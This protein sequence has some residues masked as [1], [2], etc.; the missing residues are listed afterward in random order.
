MRKGGFEPPPPCEDQALNLARLPAPP[1]PLNFKTILILY[2]QK[3][4]MF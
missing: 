3:S 4:N 2:N 1:L